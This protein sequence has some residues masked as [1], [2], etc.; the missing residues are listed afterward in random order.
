MS[1]Y[2]ILRDFLKKQAIPL[3]GLQGQELGA[4][5]GNRVGKNMV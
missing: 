5:E 4:N 3:I 1:P 2:G